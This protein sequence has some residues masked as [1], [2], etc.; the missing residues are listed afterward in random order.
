VRTDIYSAGVVLFEMLSGAA[1]IVGTEEERQQQRYDVLRERVQHQPP[2]LTRETMDVVL[3]ATHADPQQ[4]FAT[5][6]EMQVALSRA[7]HDANNRYTAESLA[8]EM[9]RLFSWELAQENPKLRESCPKDRLLFQLSRAGLAIGTD[10]SL[11]DLLQLGTVTIAPTAP[12]PKSWRPWAWSGGL[13]V[14]VL[15]TIALLSAWILSGS[16]RPVASQFV[17][18]PPRPREHLMQRSYLELDQEPIPALVPSV[19]PAGEGSDSKGNG[20]RAFLNVNSW[21]WSDVWVSGQKLLQRTPLFR[22]AVQPGE[23]VIRFA[24]R[25]RRSSR[26]V[27]IAVE[28]GD[29]MTVSVNLKHE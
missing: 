3:K 2:L 12:P 15:A 26:E 22:V 9:G 23:H 18:T 1:P 27:R 6:A 7:L 16:P 25:E 11:S 21:P 5:A 17:V 13:A 10:R 28:A 8:R 20:D 29:V 4:R 24:S 19:A 14:F